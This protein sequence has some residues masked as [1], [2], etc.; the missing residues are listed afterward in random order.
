[1][2]S[3]GFRHLLDELFRTDVTTQTSPALV[4]AELFNHIFCCEEVT[5]DKETVQNEKIEKTVVEIKPND[6]ETKNNSFKNKKKKN[7]KA[8]ADE[9][10]ICEISTSDVPKASNDSSKNAIWR[11][12]EAIL[13]R[14]VEII[15]CRFLGQLYLVNHPQGI[16]SLDSKALTEAFDTKFPYR[17]FLSQRIMPIT[18]LRR[19]CQLAGIRIRSRDYNYI[20]TS[21]T[22]DVEDIV[23]LVPRVKS[24]V[25]SGTTYLIFG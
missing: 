4:I 18:L 1:M 17:S 11:D 13:K 25:G 24:C 20:T 8:T 7:K 14:L 12:R 9:T 19:V 5:K 2:L 6:V 15:R 16:Q 21:K 23:G 3:R 22:F 10:T